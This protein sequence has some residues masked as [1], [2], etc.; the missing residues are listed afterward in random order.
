[1]TDPITHANTMTEIDR[2]NFYCG[3]LRRK[4]ASLRAELA[5]AK[6]SRD[7]AREKADT[8]ERERDEARRAIESLT[9][10]G[11]EF[12]NDP[13]ACVEYVKQ[14]RHHLWE[15]IKRFK[16]RSDALERRNA[17]LVEAV[18]GLV[19]SANDMRRYGSMTQVAAWDRLDA[20][21]AR[22]EAAVK[23]GK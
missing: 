17:A 6:M 20:A 18:E 19:A 10:N 8:L 3:R 21:L 23:G 2:L 1:M 12:V 16:Y 22:A 5:E 14:N 15:S 4:N 7:V 11:S 13:K 9:P